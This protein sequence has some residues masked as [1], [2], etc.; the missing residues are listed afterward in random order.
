MRE[1]IRDE[2]MLLR[3]VAVVGVVGVGLGWLEEEEPIE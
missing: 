2:L 1:M 3:E